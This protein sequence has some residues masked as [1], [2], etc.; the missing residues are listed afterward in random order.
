[1]TF[2]SKNFLHPKKCR[3][4]EKIN[5]KHIIIKL[6]IF[7]GTFIKLKTLENVFHCSVAITRKNMAFVS[8]L[9]N[10]YELEKCCLLITSYR[11]ALFLFIINFSI[12]LNSAQYSMNI[13]NRIFIFPITTAKYIK[14]FNY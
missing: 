8:S 7:F 12:H 10:L 13:T 6:S 5:K 2:T 1:M 14:T 3:H 4:A 11:L 9:I